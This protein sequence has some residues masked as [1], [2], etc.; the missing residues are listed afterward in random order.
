MIRSVILMVSPLV[1]CGGCCDPVVT[2]DGVGWAYNDVC[3]DS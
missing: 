1:E 2:S 3:D